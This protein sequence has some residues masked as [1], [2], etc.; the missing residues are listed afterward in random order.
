MKRNY[1]DPSLELIGRSAAERRLD[2]FYNHQ[3]STLRKTGHD[4]G[5]AIDKK[6]RD[7]KTLPFQ[8]SD[9]SAPSTPKPREQDPAT[10]KSVKDILLDISQRHLPQRLKFAKSLKLLTK[11]CKSYLDDRTNQEYET[12]SLDD[13]FNIFYRLDRIFIIEFGGNVPKDCLDVKD[14]ALEFVSSVV[15]RLL[16][17]KTISSHQQQI[18]ELVKLDIGY[19]ASLWYENDSFRFH[20]IVSELESHFKRFESIA[21]ECT[22]LP[23]TD[24][25]SDG[26]AQNVDSECSDDTHSR[27]VEHDRVPEQKQQSNLPSDRDVLLHQKSAFV[28]ILAVVFGFLTF[29][30]A[31]VAIESL[32]QKVYLRREMFCETDQQ[33][34]SEWQ[35]RIK[36]SKG[37]TFKGGS[38]AL[39]IGESSFEVQDAREEKIVCTHGSQV[40]SNRQF[41]I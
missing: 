27:D 4:T 38:V 13:F 31:K 12:V 25:P 40:W 19:A 14:A 26:T 6:A 3:R 33:R 29:P 10:R 28:R 30:W 18:L 36:A 21:S 39:G 20:G 11:L 7:L 16:A 8:Q 17:D 41:G 22:F 15:D 1:E 34:I 37:K 5:A 24:S 23:E 35:K 2:R 9:A 32:F